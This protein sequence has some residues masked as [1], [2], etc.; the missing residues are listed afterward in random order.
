MSLTA[1]LALVTAC[2][3]ALAKATPGPWICADEHGLMPGAV[4]AWCVSKTNTKGKW[5]G[6][7]AYLPQ[8]GGKEAP[9]ARVMAAA[10]TAIS[11]ALSLI[12]DTLN[13][14]TF[15]QYHA[16]CNWCSDD[17]SVGWPCPDYADAVTA[18][19]AIAT[20]LGVAA[21]QQPK[22]PVN[23]TEAHDRKRL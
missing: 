23:M 9:D 13:R 8:E 3:D 20:A 4:P 16:E 2:R 22:A 12:E 5:A 11:A 18:L 6:D 19:H 7:I 14:H 1:D 17:V 10:P 15:S 21:P